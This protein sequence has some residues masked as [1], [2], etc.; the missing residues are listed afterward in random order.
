[1]TRLAASQHDNGPTTGAG[2]VQKAFSRI[3]LLLIYLLFSLPFII[4][5]A[6]NALRSNNNSPIDWVDSRFPARMQY[7][8]FVDTFGPGDAVIV[9]WTGCKWKDSRLDRLVRTWRNSPLFH[10]KN[11]DPSFWH[12]VSGRESLRQMT[13][14]QDS[15]SD[16][17]VATKFPDTSIASYR[18]DSADSQHAASGI[19]ARG[20]LPLA[21]AIARLQGT[22][23]GPDSE[24]TCL[25]IIFTEDALK[26]RSE[27]VRLIRRSITVCCDVPDQQIHLAG[28]VIDGLSVDEASQNALA[29]FAVPSALV[30]LLICWW[31]LRSIKA[32]L[33]VFSTAAFCQ[34]ATLAIIDYS[35]ETL[36]ALLI[37]LP[38]LVQ[39]LAVAGGIH[40]MNYYFDSCESSGSQG[41][42]VEAFRKGWLP[43]TLSAATTAMGTASL[44]VSVLTPIRLFGVYA[45]I[46]VILTA[47]L[48]LTLIPC[49][50]LLIPISRRPKAEGRIHQAEADQDR[51]ASETPQ[52]G[53]SESA[54]GLL[55]NPSAETVWHRL[56]GFLNIYSTAVV[57]AGTILILIAAV[58]LPQVT[59]SVRIETLFS[60]E[61]R[62]LQDYRWL[63][64]NIGPLVPI[65]VL[66]HFESDSPIPARKRLEVLDKL[67]RNIRQI[68]EILS[69]TSATTFFPPM[70]SLKDMPERVRG[71]AINRILEQVKPALET[72]KVLVSS[73]DGEIWRI[74]GHCR[75]L[76]PLDYGTMLS[77]IEKVS[78]AT[79]KECLH[80]IRSNSPEQ[81]GCSV[82]ATGIM[83]LVH[84]IQRQLLTDLFQSMLSALVIITLTMTILEGGLITGL[85]AMV[86]N[87]FPIVVMFGMLGW[88]RHPIDI[89]S[90]MTASIALGIAVDDTLHF[91]TFFRRAIASG[92]SR[93]A[94][95]LHSFLH[96]GN[97]MVQT[98]VSCG[99]GLMVFAFSDFVP[100][101]RFA[102]LMTVLLL[103]A[104]AGDLIILP[105][106]LLSR[107][108]AY[109]ER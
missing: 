59:T 67:N 105:A 99:L 40:L 29:S 61:S 84:Q 15:D 88:L 106:L 66:V 35:G 79:L 104:L 89:G 33:L 83:P 4:S 48:V 63:E 69:T 95:V 24:S 32:A 54:N 108:G 23:I 73:S 87:I 13:Q 64:Q 25:V 60:P 90:V 2:S 19:P 53:E 56:H 39:V 7:E 82:L 52:S 18:S 42:A 44:M 36:S 46:G 47:A 49:G 100:T 1:M 9:S 51:S 70:P 22:L 45:T 97:A 102:V 6:A 8:Q 16:S 71:A 41:A 103:L 92:Q 20:L 26:R 62:I 72:A 96:C 94:A 17:E 98:S 65:E 57:T 55:V 14:P 77:E 10:E 38:P 85:F 86:S 80:T 37:I 12:V 28:P 93:K 107:A 31:S 5:G 50:L 11:G 34:A 76:E 75:S 81:L 101:S 91:L 21:T 58:G 27:L 74:T 109:F 30:I 43:C 3:R 68:P 78:S